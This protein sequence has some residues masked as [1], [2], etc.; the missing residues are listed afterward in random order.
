[1]IQLMS[2]LS[3][4]ASAIP[5]SPILSANR[6]MLYVASAESEIVALNLERRFTAWSVQ[7]LGSPSLAQAVYHT[8]VTTSVS[9][10]YYIESLGGIVRQYDAV[11]GTLNWMADCTTATVDNKQATC[12]DVESD[13]VVSEDR[14][15]FVDVMGNLAAWKVADLPVT[16]TPTS[17]PT[18]AP[19]QAPVTASLQ[20]TAKSG[21]AS[22]SVP[23]VEATSSGPLES[24]SAPTKTLDSGAGV[25]DDKK[26]TQSWLSNHAAIVASAAG[27]LLLILVLLV[28]CMRRWK[29]MKAAKLGRSLRQRKS[30][31]PDENTVATTPEPT[32]EKGF[33]GIG[34]NGQSPLSSIDEAP[35][36]ETQISAIEVISNADNPKE[37]LEITAVV[38]NLEQRFSSP[39]FDL[40]EGDAPVDNLNPAADEPMSR[41]SSDQSGFILPDY[42]SLASREK[43]EVGSQSGAASVTSK[44]SS[45]SKESGRSKGSMR[46]LKNLL[47]VMIKPKDSSSQNDAGSTKSEKQIQQSN[48]T[49]SDVKSE[50]RSITY[51][52]AEVS[53]MASPNPDY[54]QPGKIFPGQYDPTSPVLSR[55]SPT[56]SLES[57]DGS[58]YMDEST[59]ASLEMPL[60]DSLSPNLP[61]DVL[62]GTV[63]VAALPSDCPEDEVNCKLQPGLVYLNRHIAKKDQD[64]DIEKRSSLIADAKR[65]QP[66]YNGVS[67]RP[68]SRSRAGIFSR[69][70][71]RIAGGDEN[72]AEECIVIPEVTPEPVVLRSRRVLVPPS[73]TKLTEPSSPIQ[74]A[75]PT[76]PPTSPPRFT[77]AGYYVEEAEPDDSL[78]HDT[79][80]D[81][82]DLN[83][84]VITD[85][86]KREETATRPTEPT[87][88]AAKADPWFSFLNELSKVEN[89]FF[90]PTKATKKKS[91]KKERSGTKSLLKGR[92]PPPPPPPPD[93]ENHSESD[94]DEELPTPPAPR[95]FYA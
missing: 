61:G 33:E 62:A 58:L 81:E 43:E 59:I 92:P 93:V 44:G 72:N 54:L 32:N 2:P 36:E 26:S 9:V 35:D 79:T 94:D 45:R 95:T 8:D 34:S 89:Q 5:N 69:R 40:E 27:S 74:S 42:Y 24:T 28:I 80:G 4:F 56:Q 16:R 21:T 55:G 83:I 88:T 67:V 71:P 75:V 41:T 37:S 22:T 66:M 20:P 19:T 60:N 78:L 57:Y 84:P 46:S 49:V 6:S 30:F 15:Y 77:S 23:T 47:G 70:Q 14:L 50:V 3:Y 38:Q 12:G 90:N 18:L 17:V 86:S 29:R 73:A 10:V 13:F 1:M 76:P 65:T 87:E 31:R 85:G 39:S 52:Q 68:A 11:N 63:D 48:S 51:F 82:E 25:T 7:D 53:P 64:V 91:R